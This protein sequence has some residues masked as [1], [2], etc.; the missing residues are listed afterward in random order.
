[1]KVLTSI[2][3]ISTAKIAAI[4]GVLWAVLGWAM[5]SVV[6]SLI[7][8]SST[9][10]SDLPPSFSLGSL[11]SGI[12]GGFIGGGLSGY[13]GGLVYNFLARHIGGIKAVVDE[14]RT[15]EWKES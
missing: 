14:E 5:S 4:L 2:D 8:G 3:P 1:M 12:V 7:Q 10:L 6:I 15:V 11:L 13:L 9:E